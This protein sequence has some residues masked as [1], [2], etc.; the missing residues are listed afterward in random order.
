RRK[1]KR[2]WKSSASRLFGSRN[3]IRCLAI[4]GHPGD[5][6]LV[7][8]KAQG[9]AASPKEAFAL[10]QVVG[11][12]ILADRRIALGHLPWNAAHDEYFLARLQKEARVDLTHHR[13]ALAWHAHDDLQTRR[14]HRR[15][16]GVGEDEPFLVD[17]F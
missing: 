3:P 13:A 16:T 11:A 14:A 15:G 12:Q 4:I 10:E 2:L 8:G 7:H 1:T 9:R 5:I 17:A 6:H